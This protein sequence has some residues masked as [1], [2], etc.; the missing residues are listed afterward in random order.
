MKRKPTNII[1]MES[2]KRHRNSRETKSVLARKTIKTLK[3]RS[4]HN[5]IVLGVLEYDWPVARSII[6][7]VCEYIGHNI[8]SD[9]EPI[10]YPILEFALERY[11]KFLFQGGRE[12]HKDFVRLAAFID[13]IL[14]KTCEMAQEF[15]KTQPKNNKLL[16][17][18]KRTLSDWLNGE[19]DAAS[20]LLLRRS[21][22][23]LV[24]NRHV[25]HILKSTNYEN[26][27]VFGSLGARN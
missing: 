13:G 16:M 21:L 2:H 10:I 14:T 4:R 5:S 8:C 20:R 18:N 25:K 19:P 6:E 27:V 11:S 1:S 22:Y 3:K 17:V 9:D 23:D 24:A 12:K 7:I 26:A 15:I